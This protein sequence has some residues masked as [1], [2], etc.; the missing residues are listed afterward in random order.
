[1]LTGNPP[2]HG[3]TASDLP[4]PTAEFG[5]VG[6]VSS[7]GVDADGELFVIDYGGTIYRILP[8]AP[9]NLRVTTVGVP[10]TGVAGG[11]INI[12]NRIENAGGVTAVGPFRVGFY[13]SADS[14]TPG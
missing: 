1:A 4:E 7:F 14:S 13:L 12:T 10:A 8:A 3:A 11:T 5:P 2:T 6:G 9:P